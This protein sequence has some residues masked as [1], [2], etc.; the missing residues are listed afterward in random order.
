MIVMVI[1][2]L[3]KLMI[4][5]AIGWLETNVCHGHWVVKKIND[6]PGRWVVGNK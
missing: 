3:K 4:V 1:G 5:L 6:S 2:W